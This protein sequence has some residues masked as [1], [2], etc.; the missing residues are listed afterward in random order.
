MTTEPFEMRLDKWLWAARF[1][2]TRE[3]AIEA[4]NGGKV[5][6]NGQRTKPGK[7]IVP[8][9]HLSIHKD[10]LVWDIE[11]LALSMQRRPA[12]E[13]VQLYQE[14]MESQE[15]RLQYLE[16]QRQQRASGVSES[17]GRPTKRDR[18]A[19]ERLKQG[20]GFR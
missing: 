12:R 17:S 3:L 11:I 9:A 8:G 16:M 5:H 7:T 1:F 4:V 14:S 6:L 15:R 20:D 13:A 10:T 18:R 19:V 2:K